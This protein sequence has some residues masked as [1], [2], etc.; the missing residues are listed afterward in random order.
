MTHARRHGAAPESNEHGVYGTPVLD[1]FEPNRPGAFTGIEVFAVL[2]Q[3]R[4]FDVSHL[5]RQT[6]SIVKVAVDNP[7]SRAQC[8]DTF[9]L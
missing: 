5:P 1:E 2:N 7:H 8:A 3:K 6:A 9:Q 4:A